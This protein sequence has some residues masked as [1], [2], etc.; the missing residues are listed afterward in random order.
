MNKFGT[1]FGWA[2]VGSLA[3]AVAGCSGSDN[4][5]ERDELSDGATGGCQ[6]WQTALCDWIEGCGGVVDGCREQV[7]MTVCKSDSKP[8]PAPRIS[9]MQVA[10]RHP[11]GATSRAWSTRH[12]PSPRASRSSTPGA[13]TP[14]SVNQARKTC[15]SPRARPRSLARAR[16]ASAMVS[17]TAWPRSTLSRAAARPRSPSPAAASYC[18]RTSR[19]RARRVARGAFG[20][21]RRATRRGGRR[22]VVRR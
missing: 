20:A 9:E 13:G 8:G 15:A 3:L 22:S 16:S 5:E 2:F 19:S 14:R 7:V 6:A 10:R 11:T 21:P 18:S 1:L 17:T 4:D 12:R